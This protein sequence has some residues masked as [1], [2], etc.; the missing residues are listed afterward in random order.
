[1]FHGLCVC[2]L[3]TTASCAKTDEPIDMLFGTWTRV[4]H[5]NH[6]LGGGGGSDPP[7]D[8]KSKFGGIAW[9]ISSFLAG[10]HHTPACTHYATGQERFIF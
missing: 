2:L 8:E 9:T 10:L 4:G 5:R 7:P 3:V 6:I 1:M